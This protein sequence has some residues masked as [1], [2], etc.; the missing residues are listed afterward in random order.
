MARHI[1][2]VEDEPAIRDNYADFLRRQG[3]RVDTYADR[4]QASEA[5][6]RSEPD[7]VILDIGLGDDVDGGFELCRMLRSRSATLPIIFLTARDSDFDTVAGLRI[8][9]DDYVTK[10]VSLHQLSA[11]VSALLRR[12]DGARQQGDGRALIRQGEL[13]LDSEQ[14]R[15]SWRG[16]AVALTVTELWILHALLLHPGHVKSREQL[17]QAA[18]TYVDL[19]TITSHIKRIRRKFLTLDPAFDA[20]EAVYGAGYRWRTQD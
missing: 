16:E 18:D 2:I 1:A 7:L 11:R 14:M 17:M 5:L 9:A 10:N 19:A 15:V 20:I 13:V 8:G 4:P 3:Y 6:Q 12:V